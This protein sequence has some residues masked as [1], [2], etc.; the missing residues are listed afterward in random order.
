MMTR[1]L[2]GDASSVATASEMD[3]VHEVP[4]LLSSAALRKG[5]FDERHP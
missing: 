4:Q 2:A 3:P 1:A 5:H